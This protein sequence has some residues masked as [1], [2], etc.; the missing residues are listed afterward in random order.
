MKKHICAIV[1]FVLALTICGCSA[2]EQFGEE[3]S[4]SES[5]S[6]T[7]SSAV[8]SSS[9]S[10]EISSVPEKVYLDPAD[11]L[12][13][14][15]DYVKSVIKEHVSKIEK[16][17]MT[18][19]E[20]VKV[21]TDYIISIGSY[22]VS[23]SLDVWRYRSAGDSVPTYE[24]MRAL[25]MLLFGAETCEGYA[26]ALNLILNEMGVETNLLTG[27]VRTNHNGVRGLG[28][29]TWSQVKVDGVWYHLDCNVEDL[30]SSGVVYYRYF[31]KS[32]AAMSSTHYWG[33][34][35]INLGQLEEGQV[36]DVRGKYMGEECPQ[37][38]PTPAATAIPVTERPDVMAIREE[39]SK[40]LADYEEKFGELEYMPLDVVPHVFIDYYYKLDEVPEGCENMVHFA[41]T[42]QDRRCLIKNPDAPEAP[43]GYDIPWATSSMWGA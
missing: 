33:Q 36:A 29:H 28:Y 12:P 9:S 2:S 16:P 5:S 10:E 37:N 27:L 6:M 24:E 39:L 40:E 38:Y 4:S 26:S 22:T 19:F 7:Q 3:N 20:K 23:P 35:L 14:T 15:A 42:Y 13:S 31:L 34:R 1:S 25:N 11:Y 17:D 32:D 18:E 41:K 8:S 43:E 30:N 21:A